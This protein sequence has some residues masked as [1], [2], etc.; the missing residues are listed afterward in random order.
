MNSFTIASTTPNTTTIV[1][2]VTGY[3]NEEFTD[4]YFNDNWLSGNIEFVI[5]S[6]LNNFPTQFQTINFIDFQ[7]QLSKLLNNEEHSADFDETEGLFYFTVTRKIE[8]TY[9]VNVKYY[10][11]ASDRSFDLSFITSQEQLQITQ[12]MLAGIIRD[13]PERLAG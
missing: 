5:D 11:E 1:V 4:D 9:S 12:K 2:S 6:E 8:S 13:Y 3:S 10:D 7:I